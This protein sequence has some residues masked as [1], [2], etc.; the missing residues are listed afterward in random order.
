VARLK[1]EAEPDVR[2]A[3]CEAL[4]RIPYVT[5]AQ[6]ETAERALVEM[7]AR[8]ESV[9]DRLGVAKGL[10]AFVRMQRNLRAPGDDA[11]ALLRPLATRS[12][13]DPAT[14]VRV[15]RLALEA[16]VAA[17]AVDTAVVAT[18]SHDPDVQVRR[19]A[20]RAAAAA[21]DGALGADEVH[22]VLSL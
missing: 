1:L 8:A 13:A 17:A 22:T 18:A 6:A 20:M 7:A 2:A 15:R 9:T 4:G 3:I 19:M 16:L 11:L 10:E 21:A 14:G 12:G 5:S